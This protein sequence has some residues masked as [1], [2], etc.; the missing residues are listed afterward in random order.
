MTRLH[1][2][3]PSDAAGLAVALTEITEHYLVEGII[4]DG[5][6]Y[7]EWGE[8]RRDDDPEH[9]IIE[10]DYMHADGVFTR[11]SDLGIPVDATLADDWTARVHWGM[12]DI[13][14]GWEARYPR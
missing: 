7:R 5:D 13:V 11:L 12:G 1:I 2:H 9:V 8:R 3:L 6:S 4:R 10:V 14:S